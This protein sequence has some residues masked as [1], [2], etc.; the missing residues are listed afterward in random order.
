MNI[1]EELFSKYSADEEKLAA[2]GFIKRDGAYFYEKDLAG[3]GLK[4]VVE[5]SGEFKGRIID[6]AFGEEYV[7]YRLKDATGFSAGVKSRFTDLLSDIRDK[8]CEKRLYA[9]EQAVRLNKFIAERLGGKPEFLW[10]KYPSFS[11]YRRYDNKKWY[12]LFGSI[13]RNKADKSESEEE[14]EI[15]NLKADGEKVAEL[16]FKEGY[17]EAYHMNKKSWITVILDGTV[18]NGEIEKLILGSY[19]SAGNK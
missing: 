5:Y 15:I 3:D 17:F 6:T 7:N 8:C 18:P 12:A 19:A 4:I 9:T 11:I 13:P 2:Y 14:V 16:L 10:E 1:E